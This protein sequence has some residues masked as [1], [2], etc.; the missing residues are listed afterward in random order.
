MEKMTY[1]MALSYVLDNCE[2]PADVR[3]KLVNLLESVSKKSSSSS[4]R[5]SKK[6]AENQP[7]MDTLLEAMTFE[8]QTVSD[9]IKQIPAFKEFSNQKVS[10][11]AN[12]LAKEGKVVKEI[13]KG[14]TYFHLA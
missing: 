5:P 3:E 4:D 9:F 14:K 10:Y 12:S 7:L 6:Q 2:T 11:L 1:K 13:I 8:N